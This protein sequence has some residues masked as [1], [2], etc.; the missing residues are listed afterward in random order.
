MA[1]AAFLMLYQTGGMSG[2]TSAGAAM[3]VWDP[4]G[5]V[6]LVGGLA[7]V[8]GIWALFSCDKAGG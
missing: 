8:L 1:N 3:N 2:P 6:V 4:H 5:F 7:L